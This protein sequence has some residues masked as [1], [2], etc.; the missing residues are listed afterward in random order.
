M[1]GMS[2]GFILGMIVYAVYE[3]SKLERR[4]KRKDVITREDI[5][6]MDKET[7][8]ILGIEEEDIKNESKRIL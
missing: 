8:E 3:D 4:Y 6:R 1:I 2:V 7:M 5:D